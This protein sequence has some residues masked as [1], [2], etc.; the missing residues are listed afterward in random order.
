M[1]KFSNVLFYYTNCSVHG[2]FQCGLLIFVTRL[3]KVLSDVLCL[4]AV[5][6]LLFL[7]Q[8]LYV[9]IHAFVCARVSS[10]TMLFILSSSL[11]FP[12]HCLSS[13]RIMQICESS[14]MVQY[15]PLWLFKNCLFLSIIRI[16]SFRPTAWLR[17]GLG[18]VDRS[19]AVGSCCLLRYQ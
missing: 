15:F 12:Q 3:F 11:L 19:I 16:C 17:R 6:Q 18:W 10:L 4:H 2:S 7:F 13:H 14:Q 8:T 1:W 9:F 5:F